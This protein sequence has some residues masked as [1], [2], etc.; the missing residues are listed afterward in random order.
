MT[1]PSGQIMRQFGQMENYI[2][3]SLQENVFS[4]YCVQGCWVII[5]RE[6]LIYKLLDVWAMW[7]KELLSENL[8]WLI[9]GVRLRG[10]GLI[11]D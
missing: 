11:D 1:S 9:E 6:D 10:C 5:I 7:V 2:M 4:T 3:L 8:T